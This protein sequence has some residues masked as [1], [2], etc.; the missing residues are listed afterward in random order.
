MLGETTNDR[1]LAGMSEKENRPGE[2]KPGARSKNAQRTKKTAEKKEKWGLW[3]KPHR[4]E[5]SLEAWDG[6]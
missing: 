5:R 3:R 2:L 1:C 6:D 4:K